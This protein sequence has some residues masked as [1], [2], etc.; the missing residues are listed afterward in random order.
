MREKKQYN[1][2]VCGSE[3]NGRSDKKYCD[4]YCR[5]THHYKLNE[6]NNKL[7]RRMNSR[8][9]KNRRILDKV[10]AKERTCCSYQHLLFL[11]FDFSI[12]TSIYIND[13][14]D[15]CYYCYDRGYVSKGKDQY[16]IVKRNIEEWEM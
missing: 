12:H 10:I 3:I 1:C 8:L 9:R 7:I 11:G 2:P 5:S 15:T 4:D 6:N 13:D 16:L 14:G